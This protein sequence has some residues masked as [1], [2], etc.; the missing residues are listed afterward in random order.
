MCSEKFSVLRH[1][2]KIELMNWDMVLQRRWGDLPM[3]LFFQHKTLQMQQEAMRGH[4]AFFLRLRYDHL[5]EFLNL[6]LVTI[7]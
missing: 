5:F 4:A 1:W 6:Y 3:L 7:L 2:A